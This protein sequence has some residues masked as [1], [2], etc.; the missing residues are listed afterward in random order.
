MLRLQ[1][2]H[3]H[4]SNDLRKSWS[5]PNPLV[6]RASRAFVLLDMFSLCRCYLH[7]LAMEPPFT[8]ITADPELIVL[9]HSTT[10][11]TRGS[12]LF[13]IHLFSTFIIFLGWS[14]HLNCLG[15]LLPGL[16]RGIK[17]D[18]MTIRVYTTQLYADNR[19]ATAVLLN[20]S[21]TFRECWH[22]ILPCSYR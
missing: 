22:K 17:K 18:K 8:N 5:N 4:C 12:L 15:L 10:R 19:Y 14:R 9:I 7:A 20:T 3:L 16:L 2:L 6:A 13:F 11:S 1:V 21:S